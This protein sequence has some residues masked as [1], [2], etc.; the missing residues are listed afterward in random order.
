[1]PQF[2]TTPHLEDRE[3]A[4]FKG[5]IERA[6]GIQLTEKKRFLI[7][8]RLGPI[9]RQHKC[10]TFGELYE[11]IHEN[12]QERTR[13]LVIDR[14]TTNETQWFRDQ[15]PFLIFEQVV[16]PQYVSELK[17]GK[18]KE[19]RMWSAA[20]STG[21]EPYSL[22]ISFFETCPDLQWNDWSPFKFLA[23]DISSTA[24]ARAQT[25]IYSENEM[26]RGMPPHLRD[27]YFEKVSS[28]WQVCEEVRKQVRFRQFNLLSP[29]PGTKKFD[30]IFCRNVLI[31]FNDVAK[32]SIIA[33]FANSLAP[34]GY[35]ILGAS[36]SVS[37]YSND[38]IMR[39]HEGGK[40]VFYQKK[41]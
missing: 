25:G 32:K 12:G 10:Q 11:L 27:R 15:H 18:R 33:K 37:A 20:S 2:I 4:D 23:T 3:F 38:F 6:C 41:K 26:R 22:T 34:N 28:G 24:L 29:F 8:S 40:G 39:R 21:Q 19:I 5:F 16:L 9:L 17:S 35:L 7:E 14:I 13:Q 30:I 31:Y 1:M 36:E